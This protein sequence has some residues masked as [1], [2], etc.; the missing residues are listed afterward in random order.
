MLES[1]QL[2]IIGSTGVTNGD[3]DGWVISNDTMESSHP[4]GSTSKV[5]S[6]TFI[7]ASF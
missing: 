3:G 1:C 4:N 7:R 5:I 2:Y 6:G